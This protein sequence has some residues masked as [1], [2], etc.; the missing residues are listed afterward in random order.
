VLDRKNGRSCSGARSARRSS[1]LAPA[2]MIVVSPAPGAPVMTNLRMW[3]LEQLLLQQG[4]PVQHYGERRY[5]GLL[6]HRD[7]QQISF[8]VR[9]HGSGS[10][11]GANIAHLPG[12]AHWAAF[13]HIHRHHRR[14][15]SLAESSAEADLFAIAAPAW[16]RGPPSVSRSVRKIDLHRSARDCREGR[17]PPAIMLLSS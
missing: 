5:S 6:V 12:S 2:R 10:Q 8:P 3:S 14:R 7:G 1:F 4:R 11:S 15:L 9:R 17:A 13:V 16:L